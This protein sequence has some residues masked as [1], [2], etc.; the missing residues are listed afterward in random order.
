MKHISTFINEKTED[1][2]YKQLLTYTIS[3]DEARSSFEELLT[4]MGFIDMPDQSTLALPFSTK[5]TSSDV[6]NKIISWSKDKDITIDKNDFVQ[7]FR[8]TPVK[9]AENTHH[10]GIDSRK[11]VY[12]PVTKGLK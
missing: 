2:Y 6:V 9:V 11:L 10:A 5:L 1:M 12:D 8:A 7:L 3:N 4:N